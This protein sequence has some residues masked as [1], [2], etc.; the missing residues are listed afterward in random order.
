MKLL[1]LALLLFA[2]VF[3]LSCVQVSNGTWRIDSAPTPEGWPPPTPVGEVEVKSYPPHRAAEVQADRVLADG[4]ESMFMALFRHIQRNEI[5]MT[6][7]VA[8]GYASTPQGAAPMT[9]MAF[10]YRD[11]DLGSEGIEGA[12]VV[13]DRE[14]GLYASVGVRGSYSSET[15]QEALARLVRW[16][17]DNQDRWGAVGPPRFLGYNS[18]FVPWFLRYGEVQVPVEPRR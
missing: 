17:A 2:G 1:L 14:P 8:M 12:V 6:A 13:R 11:P 7:P 4:R 9:S 16:L 18:P 5:A 10:L 3:A 15:Y